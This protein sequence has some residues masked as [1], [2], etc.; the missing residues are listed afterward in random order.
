MRVIVTL[1]YQAMPPEA[2]FET[3]REAGQRLSNRPASV[4]VNWGETEDLPVIVLEFLMKT[5]AQ[6]KVV[7][8]ISDEVQRWL[9]GPLDDIAIQF[10]KET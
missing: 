5:Q 2:E 4:V 10:A 1:T 7:S 9:D 3:I 6:Y 8:E